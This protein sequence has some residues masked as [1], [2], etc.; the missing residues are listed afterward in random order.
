MGLL[1]KIFKKVAESADD[2][3]KS[4]EKATP[5]KLKG[6]EKQI[7]KDLEQLREDTEALNKDLKKLNEKTDN[8]KRFKGL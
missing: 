6:M 8:K 3:K 5:A 4:E 1:G 2:S 7:Q